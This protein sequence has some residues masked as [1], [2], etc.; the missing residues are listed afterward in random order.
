VSF[1]ALFIRRV[2]MTTLIMAAVLFFGLLGYR[3]LPVSD[4]PTVD[5]PA[6]TVT[7]SLPGASPS[8]MAASVAT[9]L[10]R[11]FSSIAGIDTMTSTSTEGRTQVS[12]LFALDRDIDAAASDVQAAI[13][14]AQRDLPPEMPT[15]P[16]FRK[17]NPADQPVIYIALASK[18]LPLSKV[19]EYGD[20]LMAQRLSTVPGVAEVQIY[21]AQK[22]AVRVQLDPRRLATLGLGVEEVETAIREANPNLPTGTLEGPRQAFT[23]E[24]SGQLHEAAAF[25]P[26]V[27][28]YRNGSPVRLSDLGR[29]VDGVQDDRV[30]SWYNG[31]RAVVLAVKRQPGTNTVQV[32]DGIKRVL[33]QLRAQIPAAVAVDVLYDRAETIRESVRDVQL[34]LVLAIALVV[35]VI[36]VFLRNVSATIMPAVA[37]PLSIVG[38]FGVMRLLG[39][40]LDNLSLMALTL[41]VGFVVDDAIVVLENI[42]RHEEQGMSRLEA[43]LAGSRQ[44]AFTV[45]SITLSLV[46]VFI[47]VLFMGGVLG[48]LLREFAVTIAVAILISGVVSLTLTPMLASRFLRAGAE[49][50]GRVF[51]ASERAFAALLRTYERTLDWSLRH[52]GLVLAAFALSLAAT[53]VVFALVPKGFIPSEDTGRIIAFTEGPQDTSFEA[54]VQRQ[55]QAAAIV[56]ANPAVEAVMST[57]GAGGPGGSRNSGLLFVRLKPR[58]ERPRADQVVAE[59]RPALARVAGLRVYP[60]V[61]ASISIGGSL[62]SGLYQYTLRSTDPATLY[63]WVP[64]LDERLRRVPGLTDVKTSLQVAS[65]RISVQIDRE[66]AAAHGV[67]A[68]QIETALYSAYGSRQVST[69]YTPTNTYWVIMEILP[70][71]EPDPAMLPLVHINAGGGRLVPLGAVA[72]LER[73]V[74]PLSIDHIGQLP[75]VTFSFNLAPGVALSDAVQRLHAVEREVGLPASIVTSFLGA[76]Q[77]FQQSVQGMAI[78]LLVAVAVIY[79]VLGI[80]YESFVHPL[81]ILSGLPAAAVGALLTLLAFR[82]DLDIYGVVG[83]ILLIGIVKKNAIMQIDFALEAQREGKDPLAAIREGAL[84]RFRPIMM[85]TLAAIA[86]AVPIALGFGAGGRARQPLGLAVVGGL[87]LSQL[88]TLYLTPALFLAFGGLAGRLAR[89]RPRGAWRRRPATRPAAGA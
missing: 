73:G 71:L 60:Q 53:A 68:R 33:P 31:T 80:L 8:T 45:V 85:T 49:R 27:V 59:L 82:R 25:A 22:Y 55:Q 6:I 63:A 12:I 47:P 46:A 7:A 69:I 40:S 70:E 2:V 18:T 66:Q 35:L 32:V 57:A 28:A 29:V 19:N 64:K 67:T 41:S 10:E 39:Y 89:W 26:I 83:I 75:A 15:P 16:S 13:A 61:P 86:G 78:L 11:A 48:R 87:L 5:F 21:G 77:Q 62:S 23:I 56:A 44:I 51:E 42:V 24:T 36:F 79:L 37:V 54:M 43:A 30:A 88:V 72:R 65:P 17:V 1:T 81:T 76:A 38:T 34:T 58:G 20:T 4:L 3:S 9:P 52:R 50:R 14:Q 74:G 84:V